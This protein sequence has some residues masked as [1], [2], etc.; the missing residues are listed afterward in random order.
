MIYDPSLLEQ[1][2]PE[3]HLAWRVATGQPVSVMA[4]VDAHTGEV[5]FQYGLTT[6]ALDLDFK[7]AHYTDNI[8]CYFLSVD[9]QTI[10][11]EF[12]LDPAYVTDVDA[13]TG[14]WNA[15]DTYAFYNDTFGRDSYN[16]TG[17]GIEVYV[18]A[19]VDNAQFTGWGCNIIEFRDGWVSWDVMVHEFTH[20]VIN[21][22]SGLVYAN[23][24]GALNEGYSDLMAYLADPSDFTLA[25]DRTNG[26][27][28][29]RDIS[30]PRQDSEIQ[31]AS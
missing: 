30:R 4:F 16:G 28:A 24:S 21:S 17:G 3:P 15:V 6:D 8:G 26:M 20:G 14:Y 9:D 25:E 2:S 11:D 12:G 1:V 18:H 10:G 5:L 19:N 29:I 23:Q 31:T 13:D 22:S 7:D 27:G